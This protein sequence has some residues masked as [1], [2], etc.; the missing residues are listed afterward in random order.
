MGL[1]T[2]KLMFS[3]D[4]FVADARDLLLQVPIPLAS[5]N[6][7]S[8]PLANVGHIQNS[9]LELALTYQNDATEFQYNITA[10]GTFLNSEIKA[11][12]EEA[13]NIPIFGAGNVIRN[14]V[15]DPVASFFVLKTAGIFQNQSEVDTW[16]VQPG[17]RPGDVKYVDVNGDGII[18]FDDR[19]VVGD[20]MPDFEF[21]LSFNATWKGFDASIY[22][23]GIVGNYAYNE[24]N[25]WMGRYDDNGNYRSDVTYWTGEGTSNSAPKPIHSDASMNPISESDRWVEKS[26]YFRLKNLQIGWTFPTTIMKKMKLRNLRIYVTGQNLFTVTN[27]S[28]SDPEVVGAVGNNLSGDGGFLGRGYDNGGFPSLRSFT[29]GIQIGF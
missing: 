18:N 25:W 17:A 15:G 5:G 23:V 21:S 14:A 24:L 6:R 26:D 3:A 9:G 13:G 19:T 12:V 28:G 22:F 1:F 2:N 8:N 27:Y 29:G 20:A 10:N 16:E 4:Y 7:G 11:L